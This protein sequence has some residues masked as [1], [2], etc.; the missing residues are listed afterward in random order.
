MA[1]RGRS[2]SC[3]RHFDGS[4]HALVAVL[5]VL[6]LGLSVRS[7]H[8][9]ECV[10]C[11]VCF[12]ERNSCL[13]SQYYIRR[14]KDC[15]KAKL[16]CTT[17]VW[18]CPDSSMFFTWPILTKEEISYLYSHKYSGQK[19]LK[20]GHPRIASQVGFILEG[21]QKINFRKGYLRIVELGCSYGLLLKKLQESIL[22][23]AQNHLICVEPSRAFALQAQQRLANTNATVE[24]VHSTWNS[25]AVAN[26]SIDLFISSHV[27]EHLPDICV[28]F[29]DL[30]SKL[31]PGGLIFSEVPNH[32]FKYLRQIFGGEFHLTFPT[33][34][35]MEVVVSNSGFQM[36]DIK[37]FRDYWTESPN[38]KWI[39]FL[40]QKL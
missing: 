12:G 39:R 26:N 28:F 2:C 33:A 4:G 37:V 23:N 25:D 15:Q 27:L 11:P 20:E 38:G 19:H 10:Q 14:H 18:Y 36:L 22:P 31:S 8:G 40:A 35:G 24:V 30:H 6:L 16:L 21:M 34:A 32:S 29:E 17:S 9:D 13:S 7:V 3:G 5:L 1:R